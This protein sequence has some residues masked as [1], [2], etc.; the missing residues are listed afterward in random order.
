MARREAAE[1]DLVALNESEAEELVGHP[2]SPES[3]EP[4]LRSCQ[5]LLRNSYTNLK[6]VVSAGKAGAYG[7]TAKTCQF[8]PAPQVEAAST[9]GAGDAL[10]GG[11]LAAMAAGILVALIAAVAQACAGLFGVSSR[12]WWRVYASSILVL[13]AIALL[14]WAYVTEGWRYCRG[15]SGRNRSQRTCGAGFGSLANKS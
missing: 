1:I 14:S 9:A 10:L 15:A 11:V 3:P 13:G 8:C 7:L 4:F 6:M 2:F 12:N 5:E